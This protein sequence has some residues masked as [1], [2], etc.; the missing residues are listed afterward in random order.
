MQNII[1]FLGASGS[2]DWLAT[3]H[4]NGRVGL[5]ASYTMDGA[6]GAVFLCVSCGA[7]LTRPLFT[8]TVPTCPLVQGMKW[9]QRVCMEKQAR[10]SR[11]STLRMSCQLVRVKAFIMIAIGAIIC[12]LNRVMRIL[13]MSRRTFYVATLSIASE[14]LEH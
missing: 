13:W 9:A 11:L 7:S 10:V 12:L 14:T 3:T 2:P 4:A 8:H 5:L 1:C 6:F